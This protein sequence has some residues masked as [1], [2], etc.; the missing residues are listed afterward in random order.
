MEVTVRFTL[1][2]RGEGAP[3]RAIIAAIRGGDIPRY[4]PGLVLG[5]KEGEVIATIV[6][7]TTST[8]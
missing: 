2:G 7:G 1:D 5:V 3:R 6:A 4:L 8:E